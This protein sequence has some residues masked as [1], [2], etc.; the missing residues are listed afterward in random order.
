MMV[1]QVCLIFAAGIL[2]DALVARYTRAVADRRPMSAAT[3][4]GVIA[5]VNMVVL[6]AVISWMSDRGI[7]PI[8]AFAGG[9]WLGTYVTVK[10]C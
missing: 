7:V 9:N 2:A 10:R 8:I 5:V 4:S 1:L 3:L 6:G